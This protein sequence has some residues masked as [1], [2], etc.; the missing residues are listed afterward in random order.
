MST[1]P[2]TGTPTPQSEKE[3]W[4][5]FEDSEVKVLEGKTLSKGGGW[6]TAVLLISTYGKVQV[7]LY[8]W[9]EKED[10]VTHQKQWKRKQHWTVN[11]Y[12]WNETLKVIAE[13]LEKRKT[14]KP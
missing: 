6:W 3:H 8:L 7:K 10:K 14:V 13:F 12:N 1:P 11:S 4:P 5:A 9:Q 2:V